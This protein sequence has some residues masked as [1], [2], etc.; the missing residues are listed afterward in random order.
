MDYHRPD[1]TVKVG[2]V[3]WNLRVILTALWDSAAGESHRAVWQSLGVQH[4]DR[5]RRKTSRVVF[6]AERQGKVTLKWI[7][8][9]SGC[10][11]KDIC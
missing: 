8:S 4:S 5:K 6:F 9:N 2:N 11:V 7:D 1:E 10:S 3:I